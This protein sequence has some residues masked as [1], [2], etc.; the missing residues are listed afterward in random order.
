MSIERCGAVVKLA[1]AV[2]LTTVIAVSARAQDTVETFYKG[3]QI[4][5]IVGYGP[6]GGYDLTA[7]LLARHLGRFIPGNP[8]I[9]VQNM[10]GPA[11]CGRPI[12]STARRRRTALHSACSAATSP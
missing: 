4:N 5:L 3:R 9:V 1:I 2:L 6:G 10:V 12:S 11:A 7:R 8:S